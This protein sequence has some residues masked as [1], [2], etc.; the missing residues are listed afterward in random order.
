[1][2]LYDLSHAAWRT[3][4]YSGQNGGCVEIVVVPAWRTSTYS[5]T[6]GSCVEVAD[7]LPGVVA[8]RDSK[9]RGGPVLAID[10]DQWRAF[11]ERVK[12]GR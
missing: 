12:A 1:M 11:T 7:N 8:V 5:G 3:S 9:D 4:S 2:K 6:N 10:P